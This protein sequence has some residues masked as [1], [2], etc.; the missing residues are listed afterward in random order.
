V[1]GFPVIGSPYTY[2]PTGPFHQNYSNFSPTVGMDFHINADMMLYASYSK[3]YKTGSWTTRLSNPHPTY[4]ASLHF[5]PEFAKSYEL[6]FKSELLDHR[7]RLNLAAFHTKYDNIQLN[8]QVGISPTIVNAGNATIYGFEAEAQALLGAGFSLAASAGYTHAA[9]DSLN[10]V[11]DNGY[12]LT[13]TSCPERDPSSPPPPPPVNGKPNSG[14]QVQNGV[15]ELPKSPKFKANLGPQYVATLP[16]AANVQFNVDWTY[17][18]K[19]YN[20]IGNSW[21]LARP[22]LSMVNAVITYK[23]PAHVWEFALGATNLTDKRY[24]VSGQ[25]QGGV[26]VVDASYNAPRQWYATFRFN[27]G[28]ANK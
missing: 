26:A 13:R 2:Y 8:S 10:N 25:N 12:T 5:D 22:D 14:A 16:N 27:L 28:G 23:E 6:G 20:D 18:T 21:Q 19:E 3:G 11:G 7:L 15:C 4:D 9:Y 17:I 1:L 24:V